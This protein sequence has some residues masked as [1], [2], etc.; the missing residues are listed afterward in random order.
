M[1]KI[2]IL[3]I[4]ILLIG[5]TSCIDEIEIDTQE[6]PQLVG[7]NGYI[8]D[9]YKKHQ[10]VVS[11]T[12]D[13]YST[14]EIEMISG[15]EVF[16]YDGYD[17]I[18]FEETENKGYYETK[19]SISGVIGRTYFLNVNYIDDDGEHR[20][21][22]QST[23]RENVPQIDSLKIKNV[24]LGIIPG[25]IDSTLSLY[26]YFQ[27]LADQETNYLINI[28]INDSIL[29][30]SL[31]KCGSLSLMGL[32]GMY[33]NGP[34]MVS[35]VGEQSVHTFEISLYQYIDEEIVGTTA[36][37]TSIENGDKI[38]MYLY[39]ITPEFHKY[40]SDINSNFGSNPMMGMPYN[41]STN[42]YPIGKAV[43][44]FEAYSIVEASIIY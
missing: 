34:E 4:I 9:E 20:Y 18:F 31:I 13:F 35:M 1:R 22:A 28:A 10:I 3:S 40:I 7:I 16:I 15:A 2:N 33:F 17:T 23:M 44:F 36:I 25:V 39:S 30:S 38:T 8:S 32:S 12:M 14:D 26:P 11:K 24:S 37:M 29:D 19:D 5:L 27:S 6:G 43:G 41:V 21:Y 42:I